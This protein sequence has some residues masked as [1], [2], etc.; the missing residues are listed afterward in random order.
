MQIE[1]GNNLPRVKVANQTA[2]KKMI[3][4]YGPIMRSEI[5]TRLSLTLPTITTNINSMINSGI[6]CEVENTDSSS[7][8]NI[9][10]K[11]NPVD[12]VD[13]SR[14]FIGLEM[15]KEFR[16]F[17]ITNY[18]GKIIYS[19]A[20]DT[21]IPDYDENIKKTCE[22]ISQLLNLNTV[23]SDKIAGIGVCLPGI[24]D[25]EEGKLN[26]HYQYKWFDKDIR[27]DIARLTRFQG[28]ITVDNNACAR[29]YSVHLF[30]RE[31]LYNVPTFA[32]LFLSQG[33]SCPLI[34]NNSN[35]TSI[36]L[37]PGE[38]GYMIMDSTKPRDE[39]SHTG[40]LSSLAGERIILS[41]SLDAMNNGSAPFLK[42]LC[43]E[44][45]KPTMSQVLK[46]HEAGEKSIMDIIS[47]SI[48]YLGIAIANIDNFVHPDTILV[49]ARLFSTDTNRKLFLDTVYE[50][51]VRPASSAPNFIFIE[52]DEYTGAK[53]GAAI[54][55]QTDLEA[56]IE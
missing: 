54:A 31:L 30:Q 21:I 14:Y 20:D 37:G 11:A 32:Y 52:R 33:I 24:V 8:N 49:D 16:H 13:D 36:P 42:S 25:R 41:K 12:I 43:G 2:I 34:I 7:K 3:Y 9:G 5:S 46:A 19:V 6:V 40:N 26:R 50:N 56:Y 55:V 10:R 4:H 38:L 47:S 22:I 1:L 45:A 39:Y 18:R 23:S 44:S 53:G 15:R 51:S 29:A 35:F 27:N 48:T 17:C 28:T